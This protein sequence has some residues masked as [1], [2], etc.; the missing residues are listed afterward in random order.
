MVTVW[1]TRSHC[2]ST[3]PRMTIHQTS[4]PKVPRVLYCRSPKIV[5]TFLHGRRAEA[6]KKV[7]DRLRPHATKGSSERCMYLKAESQVSPLV[8]IEED[9]LER[10]WTGGKTSNKETSN[11]I[12]LRQRTRRPGYLHVYRIFPIEFRPITDETTQK[13]GI[14]TPHCP[15]E[16]DTRK[17]SSVIV[18]R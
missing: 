12:R 14:Y 11:T 2:E 6:W 8:Y 13:T 16:E 7:S 3:P 1:L 5:S 10:R 17:T 9:S 15:L 18:N 4:C